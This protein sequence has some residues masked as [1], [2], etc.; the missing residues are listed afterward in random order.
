M[1][2]PVANSIANHTGSRK[3]GVSSSLPSTMSPNRLRPIHSEKTT[4]PA[5]T[6]T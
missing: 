6:I 5:T 2:I 1:P 4:K 3:S